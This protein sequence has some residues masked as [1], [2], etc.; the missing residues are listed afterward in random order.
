MLNQNGADSRNSIK[1]I[2]LTKSNYMESKDL[3]QLTLRLL[4][5]YN[6]ENQ[7]MHPEEKYP[8]LAQ[9]LA[10]LLSETF[11]RIKDVKNAEDLKLAIDNGVFIMK[12]K[13]SNLYAY[14]HK[15]KLARVTNVEFNREGLTQ[16]PL[17]YKNWFMPGEELIINEMTNAVNPTPAKFFY[18]YL[19]SIGSIGHQVELFVDYLKEK[20]ISGELKAV[21]NN[22]IR[23]KDLN[24][25]DLII[26]DHMTLCID[27]TVRQTVQ[28]KVEED[29]PFIP[30]LGIITHFDKTR[31][32]GNVRR[33]GDNVTLGLRAK[34]LIDP[35]ILKSP[36][37]K[38]VVFSEREEIH[39]NGFTMIQATFVHESANASKMLQLAEELSKS[40]K[41]ASKAV[42]EH[43]LASD[44]ENEIALLKLDEMNSPASQTIDEYTIKYKQAEDLLNN[45]NEDITKIE[46]AIHILKNVL[47]NGKKVKDTIS[48]LARGYYR[49][50][51]LET[52]DKEIKDVYRKD[53]IEHVGKYHSMLGP[54]ASQNMRLKY[55]GLL[56]D[57]AYMETIDTILQE[58]EI[59][60]SKRALMFYYKASYYQNHGDAD[61]AK[62]FAEESL[63]LRPFGN[64]AEKILIPNLE[65]PTLP[66][67]SYLAS[68]LLAGEN[69]NNREEDIDYSQ[70][71]E[72]IAK[73]APKYND[74]LLWAA[75]D[76][77]ETD[78]NRAIAFLTEYIASQALVFAHDTKPSSALYYWSE[79]FSNI[80]PGFGYYS[81]ARFAE[82]LAHI[83]NIDIKKDSQVET[84]RPW[85]NRKLWDEVLTSNSTITEYQWHQI[86]CAI[87]NNQAICQA[88][89]QKIIDDV[90]LKAAFAQYAGV[91]TDQLSIETIA[92]TIEERKTLFIQHEINATQEITDLLKMSKTVGDLCTALD[93]ISPKRQP[94]KALSQRNKALLKHLIEECLPLL[95]QY[96][97]AVEQVA[98]NSAR[99]ELNYS[100]KELYKS[101][102]QEPTFFSV[103]AIE[104]I[105]VK[106]QQ[107]FNITSA[108]PEVKLAITQNNVIKDSYGYYEV[109]GEVAIAEH[110]QDA[111]DV[112][113]SILV[114][115]GRFKYFRYEP[116][117]VVNIGDVRSG[118]TKEFSFRVKFDDDYNKP[119]FA[120]GVKCE[121]RVKN[122]TKAITSTL[123]IHFGNKKPFVPITNN[124]YTYGTGL[125]IDDPT[126]VGRENDIKELVNKVLHPQ[127]AAS[128][129][130][131]YGQKR[132]GKTSLVKAVMEN[133]KN[134]YP[135]QAWCVFM[136]LTIDGK[137]ELFSDRD[138]YRIILT[139]IRADLS[140]YPEPKP[141]LNM[142]TEQQK[143]EVESPTQL[144]CDTIMELK[145][146]MA[147]T[148]GWEHKRLVLILDEFTLLY[149]S[150]KAG[151]ASENIMHN[152]KAIQESDKTNFVTIFVGHDISDAFL[153]E[154]YAI[155]AAAIIERYRLTYLKREEAIELI[156]K[157]TNIDGVSRFET[158]AIEM[159]LDYT[160]CSPYFLQMFMRRMV[161]YINTKELATVTDHDVL[162]VAQNFISKQYSEMSSI[163]N[164]DSLINCGLNDKYGK[165]KDKDIEKVLREISESSDSQS[166]WCKESK[167]KD[168][169]IDQQSDISKD[170]VEGIIK[171]LESRNVI[172]IKK[173]ANG[174][175]VIRIII[176]IFRE[177]LQ[178]N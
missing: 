101:I 65:E 156:Q 146:S 73:S 75:I 115:K 69:F 72:L 105:I 164:F 45:D 25:Q 155:N 176:G 143:K 125:G 90:N 20:T 138:F 70:K 148:P 64:N 41:K 53:L 154:P 80:L 68:C 13:E 8:E 166:F 116:Y 94:F 114:K 132:C 46:S 159:I 3:Q 126:F 5:Y 85:E 61:R 4:G 142:P 35:K 10:E 28:Q 161:E 7:T 44:P 103:K 107:H 174:E 37:G 149:N 74:Y 76:S 134:E 165:Y 175:H 32:L 66:N 33:Y 141:T 92:N 77:Q 22:F 167:V 96:N 177:W 139:A 170:D 147:I 150:I 54:G 109:K 42:L 133:L 119:S 6:E 91:K 14:F 129:V 178:R 163:S 130:I 55:Y 71:I 1:V 83:L 21:G 27:P 108:E 128:Q 95:E 19:K 110:E 137:K 81:R 111:K 157:P 162:M 48:L 82:F 18:E 79:L 97:V 113:L 136:T 100:L 173:D 160:G 140:T 131:L 26:S 50:Y 40:D 124:P 98:K 87:G 60:N 88:V 118:S 89:S 51:E 58:P 135:D 153:H 145:Q 34:E 152:W 168:A 59:K 169:L 106:I 30:A 36:E 2:D 117:P 112:K 122:I 23:L 31:G 102:W 56:D 99:S 17:E 62:S 123:E 52:D 57:K 38:K 93:Q 86:F 144:F 84:Y 43:I 29:D 63:Y 121:Y 67:N 16:L 151:I 11:E 127:R 49:R 172:E 158:T 9:E 24:D 78:E 15:K 47:D 12:D 171:D 39:H 104:P 120:F